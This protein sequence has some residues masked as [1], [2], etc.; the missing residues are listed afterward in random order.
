MSF[1]SPRRLVALT[2]LA[3]AGIAML[4]TMAPSASNASSHREAPFIATQPK[5]EGSPRPAS[6]PLRDRQR[7][8]RQHDCQEPA[9]AGRP[10]RAELPQ[11]GPQGA[12]RR[13]TGSQKNTSAERSSG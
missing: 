9:P 12:R 7:R 3:S 6:Q 11:D 2:S 1:L 10:R 4:A 8:L 5:V 13:Q